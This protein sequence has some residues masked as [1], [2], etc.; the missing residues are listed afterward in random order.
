M[1]VQALHNQRCGRVLERLIITFNLRNIHS[2]DP[3]LITILLQQVFKDGEWIAVEP[4]P[5]AFVET[6]GLCYSSTS[7]SLQF[8]RLSKF[9]C[10][11]GVR[12]KVGIFFQASLSLHRLG[13]HIHTSNGQLGG[14][15]CIQYGVRIL[16]SWLRSLCLAGA[17]FILWC[18]HLMCKCNHQKED[19]DNDVFASGKLVPVID[20]GGHDRV[21]ITRLFPDGEWIAVEQFPMPLW[22]HWDCVTEHAQIPSFG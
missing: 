10:F 20:L 7:T 16:T 18:H 13:T 12:V 17:I 3:N 2:Q 14:L 4:I 8:S 6:L 1:K 9:G 15:L 19:H 11:Q 22:K 21:D 5:N